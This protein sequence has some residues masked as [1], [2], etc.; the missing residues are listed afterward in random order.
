[1]EDSLLAGFGGTDSIRF[2]RGFWFKSIKLLGYPVSQSDL[3]IESLKQQRVLSDFLPEKAWLIYKNDYI[4]IAVLEFRT[5]EQALSRAKTVKIAR[6]WKRG[7][8]IRPILILTDGSSSFLAIIPGSD[9]S[10]S[11]EV[12]ILHLEDRLYRTDREVLATLVYPQGG[13]LEQKHE[14][15]LRGYDNEF[16][17]YQRVRDEFFDQYRNLYSKIE[18]IVHPVLKTHSSAYAQRFLGR[19]MFLYFLQR[20]SWLKNDKRYVANIRDFRELNKVFYLGLNQGHDGLPFLNGS[21]FDKEDY[22]TKETEN[23][24]AQKM[25]SLFYD[26]RTFF[27]GYNFTVDEGAPLEVEVSLDPALIGTVFENMLPE[28]ERGSKGTFYTPLEESAFICKRAIAAHL[29]FRDEVSVDGRSFVDG[30]DR[31]V[32][33][34][35]KSKNEADIRKYKERLL[36]MKILDPAVGSGGFLLVAMQVVIDIVQRLDAIVGWRTDVEDYKKRILPNLYGFDIE[37]EAIE[38]A[39]LRLW[40]SLIIDQKSPEPLPNLDM[41]IVEIKDSLLKPNPQRTL[42]PKVELLRERHEAL[43]DKYIHEHDARKKK[44]LKDEMIKTGEELAKKTASDPNS[45]EAFIGSKIDILVMNPPYVR[46]EKIDKK[47]KSYYVAVYG[48][49]AKADVY[50]YFILRSFSLLNPN[51]VAA[52]ISSEAW[53]VTEYGIDLQR[54]IKNRLIGVYCQKERTFSADV[55]TVISVYSGSELGGEDA[56]DFTYVQAYGFANVKRHHSIPRKD[57][58]PGKWFYLRVSHEILCVILPKLPH[59]MRNFAHVKF[60]IKTGA[61]DFFHLKD[62]SH[63]YETDYIA[64]PKRFTDWGIRAKTRRELETSELIYVENEGGKRFV[65]DRKDTLAI[66]RTPKKLKAHQIRDTDG[67]CLYTLKPGKYTDRYIHW[68]E[69]Q[70]FKIDEKTVVGYNNT[71]SCMGRSPWY[72]LADIDPTHV[73]LLKSL[74]EHIIPYSKEPAISSDRFYPV[75]HKRIKQVWKYL[76]STLFF[77]TV[78]MYGRRQLKGVLDMMVEDYKEIIVPDLDKID[79]DFDATSILRREVLSYHEEVKQEDRR[80]LDIAVL[81]A[82]GFG[83]DEAGRFVKQLHEAFVDAAEDR[84]T[85]ISNRRAANQG[86]DD[87]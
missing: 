18:K 43:R 56:V 9:M 34:L 53:L 7:R 59:K 11:G 62:M 72:K 19:L 32:E 23:K 37:P 10:G 67:L 50:A 22:M 81:K 71:A 5:R 29:G 48:I 1:M 68:G 14:T 46:Q 51:G 13:T 28:Y 20:K 25:D 30:I 15:L 87:N 60:G 65:I 66:L 70:T 86:D 64:D 16:L 26:V 3:D 74:D 38:I 40:L 44:L 45:I 35:S 24:L 84:L 54:I 83:E 2:D 4:E 21:L 41:N 79:I 85:K 76:A 27:D 58:K 6:A 82:L 80:L 8:L 69:K 49:D 33:Q 55:N 52:L 61:N 42:D 63:L 75:Y 39:R 77:L 47:R 31:L 36:A 57:L 73:F 17:P 78:E 12:R